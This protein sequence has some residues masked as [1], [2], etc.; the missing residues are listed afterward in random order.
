MIYLLLYLKF[1]ADD[2]A[3]ALYYSIDEKDS[4]PAYHH[5]VSGARVAD[6]EIAIVELTDGSS[7]KRVELEEL[8]LKEEDLHPYSSWADPIMKIQDGSKTAIVLFGDAAIDEIIDY[9]RF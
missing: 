4:I 8:T 3:A 6:N 9:L 1:N 5:I 7:I 2:I